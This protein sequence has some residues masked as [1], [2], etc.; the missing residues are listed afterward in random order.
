MISDLYD[1]AAAVRTYGVYSVG[2]YSCGRVVEIG[3]HDSPMAF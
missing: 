3:D 1:T 2:P